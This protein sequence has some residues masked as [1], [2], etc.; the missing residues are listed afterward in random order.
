MTIK[1]ID[2]NVLSFGVLLK[3]HQR[4]REDNSFSVRLTWSK[5]F[6]I[7]GITTQTIWSMLCMIY[8]NLV[9]YHIFQIYRG[10]VGRSQCSS[11]DLD[12]MRTYI[13]IISILYRTSYNKGLGY[14]SPPGQSE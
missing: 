3:T 6:S 12:K 2:H 1:A 10:V 13:S 5:S 14:K 11:I 4:E 7:Y 8:L 9:R